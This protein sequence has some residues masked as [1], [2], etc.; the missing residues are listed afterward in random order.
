MFS[1]RFDKSETANISK[2][3]NKTFQ[4]FEPG[5]KSYSGIMDAVTTIYKE[6]G[7]RGFFK[8]A[9]V[10]VVTVP[11]F[12][13]LY[14]PLYEH[15]KEM[16]AKLLYN[17]PNKF[18]S[19]VYTFSAVTAALTCDLI[20]NPMWVVRIRYQTEFI[21]SGKQKMD[22]F[23]VWKSIIKL[24]RKV[25]LFFTFYYLRKDFSHSIED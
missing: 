19:Y 24:Y 22:S 6:E 4:K 11:V 3:I 15:S 2:I 17:D 8:G 10:A 13:S 23:N 9:R 16:Y 7:M 1:L 12:Y 14:F 20:T 25:K 18:N 5:T 21:Y